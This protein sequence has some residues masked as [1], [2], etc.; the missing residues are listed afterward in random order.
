MSSSISFAVQANANLKSL[1]RLR[2]AGSSKRFLDELNYLL[3]GLDPSHSLSAR[4]SSSIALVRSMWGATDEEEDDSLDGS[5]LD[6]LHK[7]KATQSQS[8]IW[9]ALRE[10]GG[11]ET[12][13]VVLNSCL[14]LALARMTE[15]RACGEL[16][17][18]EQAQ[19]IWKSMER[20]LHFASSQGASLPAGQE[21]K[22]KASRSEMLIEVRRLRAFAWPEESSS[23]S[24][25]SLTTALLHSATGLLETYG[26]DPTPHDSD[27][28]Q[29]GVAA[30]K[31]QAL[32][33]AFAQLQIEASDATR[34]S[35]D[36]GPSLA[37]TGLLARLA[38]LHP[39]LLSPSSR[40]GSTVASDLVTVLQS[41][42]HKLNGKAST[43]AARVTVAWLQ[44]LVSATQSSK[45]W[46]QVLLGSMDALVGIICSHPQPSSGDQIG[47]DASGITSSGLHF[48]AS[49][50]ALALLTNLLEW[51]SAASTR[52]AKANVVG[53]V[54]E[55]CPATTT[56]PAAHLLYHHMQE[57]SSR[58]KANEDA[59]DPRGTLDFG[60]RGGQSL[61]LDA[62]PD[63]ALQATT[64]ADDDFVVGCLAV[65]LALAI[66]GSAE[67]RTT[68][69][70]HDSSCVQRLAEILE[71]F[72]ATSR[73]LINRIVS[74]SS[75]NSGNEDDVTQGGDLVERMA[76]AMSRLYSSGGSTDLDSA[77]AQV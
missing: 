11:A 47:D 12:D 19:D 67:F 22:R 29:P 43:D 8:Q 40:T 49:C 70:E 37:N 64:K 68:L 39:E 69:E 76:R 35:R 44:V 26:A 30:A 18:Q 7:I 66:E 9:L 5:N 16:L 56:T 23:S 77:T 1:T 42:C 61:S 71:D 72:A 63:V 4:Q 51:D 62:S 53:S 14:L 52:L 10:A 38:E 57:T 3:A 24:S 21:A 27:D 2:S 54:L 20:M 33:T 73:T 15:R 6:F 60:M 58:L 13:D 48:D 36:D 45:W 59:A 65:A 32:A 55:S 74:S 46:C 41:L 34:S 17:Y 50:L 28:G 25:N 31:S 75:S